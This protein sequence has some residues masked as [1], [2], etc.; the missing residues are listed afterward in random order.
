M[1]RSNVNR[2]GESGIALFI[3]LWVLVLLSVIAG[4][5]CF[6][7]RN[8]V[9][10][11]RNLID[12]TRAH[13]LAEAG[14]SRAVLELLNPDS[15]LNTQAKEEEDDNETQEEG[16]SWR[17]NTETPELAV[18]PGSFK[19]LIT[20]EGGKIN[21]N[22]ADSKMLELMLQGFNLETEEVSVIVDSILDWRDSDDL[23]RA[24][25]AEENYYQSLPSPYHCRNRM[26]SS[27]EE[28]L[29]VRGIT[30]EMFYGGLDS[31]V[32]VYPEG[33]AQEDGTPVSGLSKTSSGTFAHSGGTS[34]STSTSK[35]SGVYAHSGNTSSSSKKTVTA[36]PKININSASRA[37]LLALTQMDEAVVDQ[38]MEYRAGK[39]FASLSDFKQLVGAEIYKQVSAYITTEASSVFTIEAVGSVTDSD[40]RASV[41]AV[42]HLTDKNDRGFSILMWKDGGSEF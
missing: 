29:F 9:N 36:T 25:G 20:D 28:L 5:F 34:T 38:I 27:A 40:A 10:M 26:F 42:V 7:M 1:R 15:T 41:R 2:S 8:E 3:V 16:F 17:I 19:V 31:M 33:T 4:Q 12:R 32:T 39:N 14:I 24:N 13:Y 23:V 22:T 30:V 37:M 11:T 6:S 35:G 21:L 18:G